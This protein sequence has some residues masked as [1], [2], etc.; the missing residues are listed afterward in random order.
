MGKNENEN[1]GLK[2]LGYNKSYDKR[3]VYS[4]RDLP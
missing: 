1:N 3:E 4:N 2:P